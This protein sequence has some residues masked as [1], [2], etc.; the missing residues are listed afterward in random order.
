MTQTGGGSIGY[1]VTIIFFVLVIVPIQFATLSI[2]FRY[3]YPTMLKSVWQQLRTPAAKRWF[4]ASMIVL[5][6]AE[7][8]LV[9]WI[10]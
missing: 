9:I 10:G 7:V 2:L 3:A 8:A 4:V 5:V 6:V 1:W